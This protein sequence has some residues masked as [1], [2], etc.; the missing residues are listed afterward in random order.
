M[1]DTDMDEQ[2]Q[3]E[4]AGPVIQ[5]IQSGESMPPVGRSQPLTTFM[6]AVSKHNEINNT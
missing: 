5:S 4:S 1:V 2:Q 3:D 6:L